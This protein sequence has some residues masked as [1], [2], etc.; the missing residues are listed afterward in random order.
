MRPCSGSAGSVRACVYSSSQCSTVLATAA[1][2]LTVYNA[3][4][5]YSCLE[6]CR[7]GCWGSKS[8]NPGKI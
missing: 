1:G 5:Q 3:M 4:S 8:V 7:K 6:C 2:S